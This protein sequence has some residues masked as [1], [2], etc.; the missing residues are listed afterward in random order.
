MIHLVD[1]VKQKPIFRLANLFDYFY[2]LKALTFQAK[3][4]T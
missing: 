4:K 1:M 3:K 2:L